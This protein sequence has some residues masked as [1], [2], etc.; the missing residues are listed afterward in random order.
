MFVTW[1]VSNI[2]EGIKDIIYVLCI[3]FLPI[4]PL[5]FY[6]GSIFA[7]VWAY[8]NWE[9]ITD[10]EPLGYVEPLTYSEQKEMGQ[11]HHCKVYQE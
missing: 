3:L 6:Y 7:V 11:L 4:A 5:F 10:V 9:D 1:K 2:I 8:D